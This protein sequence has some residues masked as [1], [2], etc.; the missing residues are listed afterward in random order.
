MS[1]RLTIHPMRFENL[2]YL[3]AHP[4]RV[5]YGFVAFWGDDEEWFHSGVEQPVPGDTVGFVRWLANFVGL[6]S[7]LETAFEEAFSTQGGFQGPC[8]DWVD[9]ER[10]REILKDQPATPLFRSLTG[11]EV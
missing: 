8:F 10:L 9:Q 7:S 2:G 11:E 3:P 1:E 6:S 5:S 4:Y